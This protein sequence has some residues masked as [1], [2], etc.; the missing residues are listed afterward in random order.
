[1]TIKEMAEGAYATA[2]S[3]G[4]HDSERDFGLAIALI[5]SEASEALEAKRDT[6]GCAAHVAN[7]MK[8]FGCLIEVPHTAG[9]AT[10]YTTFVMKQPQELGDNELCHYVA[11]VHPSNPD[12][13]YYLHSST[14]WREVRDY[15]NSLIAEELAD[16]L[17]RTGDLAEEIGVDLQAAVVAKMAKNQGRPHKHGKDF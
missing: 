6:K 16:I 13:H 11:C 8:A 14:F 2:E 3:N 17:I 12:Y 9:D 4:F 15:Q 7:R 5:H 10:E 1:M